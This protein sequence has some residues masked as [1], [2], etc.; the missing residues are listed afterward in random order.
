MNLPFAEA[1]T[2]VEMVS[3]YKKT[4]DAFKVEQS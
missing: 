4:R 3:T 1:A 2:Q